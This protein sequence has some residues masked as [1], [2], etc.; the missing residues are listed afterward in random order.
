MVGILT[1]AIAI[2][3]VNNKNKAEESKKRAEIKVNIPSSK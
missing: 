1:I 2:M 3:W